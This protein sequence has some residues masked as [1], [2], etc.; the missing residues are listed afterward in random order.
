MS[1]TVLFAPRAQRQLD[2][3]DAD[4]SD[5]TSPEIAARYTDAITDYCY[6]LAT[7]PHRGARRDD[8]RQGVRITNYR[9]RTAIA[10]AV[11]DAAYVVLIIGVFYG[12]Q[13]YETILQDELDDRDTGR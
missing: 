7:F 2:K 4:I 8:I 3:L 1:Y 10:F 11:D 12:G 5:A 13:D 6:S 9:K